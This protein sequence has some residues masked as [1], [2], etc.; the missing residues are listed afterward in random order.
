VIFYQ[1]KAQKPEFGSANRATSAV[2][3]SLTQD[4]LKSAILDR[5]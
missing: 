1:N 5:T 2:R 3:I 4:W